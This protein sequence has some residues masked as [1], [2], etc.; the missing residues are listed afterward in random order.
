MGPSGRAPWRRDRIRE[1]RKRIDTEFEA[2]FDRHPEAALIRSPPDTGTVP[3]ANEV[4]M[5]CLSSPHLRVPL[6]GH[7]SHES[8][9]FYDLSG[10]QPRAHRRR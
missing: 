6:R 3:D 8:P 7:P 10:D 1:H 4:D 2:L 9:F 5:G